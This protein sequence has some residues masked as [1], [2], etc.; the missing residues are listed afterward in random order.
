MMSDDEAVA[1]AK[2]LCKEKEIDRLIGRLNNL[3]LWI[4]R[5]GMGI[6]G[7][8]ETL[9]GALKRSFEL[10]ANGKAPTSIREMP[11]DRTVIPAEQ[12]WE[13]WTRIGLIQTRASHRSL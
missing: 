11:D 10:S 5:G 8:D 3:S 9:R 12:I 4:T 13:L 6:L 2:P 7:M 1:A